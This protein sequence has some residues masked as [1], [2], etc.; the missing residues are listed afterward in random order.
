MKTER[1][2]LGFSEEM[3]RDAMAN[4]W[5]L[6]GVEASNARNVSELL[7]MIDGALDSVCGSAA[8]LAFKT[9]AQQTP[10]QIRRP[11]GNELLVMAS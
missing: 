8:H 10:A 1:H 11:T 4:D 2:A 9:M 6:C 7:R 5:I 3:L